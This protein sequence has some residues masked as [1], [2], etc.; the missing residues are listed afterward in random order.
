[1]NKVM[2][3]KNGVPNPNFKGFILDNIQT[4][5]MQCKSCMVVGV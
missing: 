3:L 4:I 2:T 5:N 1:M